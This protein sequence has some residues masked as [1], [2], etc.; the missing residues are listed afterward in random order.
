MCE[1][2]ALSDGGVW[3]RPQLRTMDRLGHG[4]KHSTYLDF[5]KC[6]GPSA[7]RNACASMELA[8]PGSGPIGDRGGASHIERRRRC[9]AAE[10]QDRVFAGGSWRLTEP[11]GRRD[12]GVMH[13]NRRRHDRHS[14]Y[15]IIFNEYF[16]IDRL[17]LK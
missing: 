13:A 12:S 17:F 8:K 3:S 14:Q 5:P 6:L 16:F 10:I 7:K 9:G 4:E 11:S 15:K 1:S 2:G